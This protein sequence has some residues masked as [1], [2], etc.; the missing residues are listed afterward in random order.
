MTCI[1]VPPAR[2]AEL[3]A[4]RAAAAAR[5]R[6]VEL[7]TMAELEALYALYADIW[8]FDASRPLVSVELL[9]ALTK[10]GNYVAGAYAAEELVGA[11]V[12]FFGAPAGAELHSHMAGVSAAA[13]GR[14]VGFALKLH[15][16]AWALGRGVSSIYWTTDPLVR[17]NAHFNIAKLGARPIEYLPNFYGRMT[18]GINRGDDSDRISL[19]WALT[20]AEVH[21]ACDGAPTIAD[22]D[23]IGA[24]TVLRCAD[25]APVP[26]ESDGA[27][28]L[29][30]LP[31][32][33]ERLRA[34]SPDLAS[35]WR[36]AVRESLGRL[37][38]RGYRVTGLDPRRGYLL[39][40]PGGKDAL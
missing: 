27:V 13:R 11:C 28:V 8:K 36:L 1:G 21:A 38:S 23:S 31:Q 30:E 19:R 2:V 24:V 26:V 35:R 17:R 9:R 33:I 29:V 12:A 16:R 6:I 7:T 34:S 14:N 39:E 20:A 32:D 40:A 5:V 18:D 4:Q 37:M 10:A 15:Q 3:Q 22:A 25:D